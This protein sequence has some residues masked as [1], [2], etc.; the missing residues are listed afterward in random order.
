[1]ITQRAAESSPICKKSR[2]GTGP[3][4]WV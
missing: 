2:G 4:R 3:P 1:L